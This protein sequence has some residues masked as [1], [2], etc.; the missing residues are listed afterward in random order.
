M[1]GQTLHSA[2]HT[3]TIHP[4]QRAHHHYAR[5]AQRLDCG[6]W[7]R[8]CGQFAARHPE[9]VQQRPQ[10]RD[11]EG[12]VGRK[13]EEASER[14]RRGE[15]DHHGQRGEHQRACILDARNRSFE[16]GGEEFDASTEGLLAAAGLA[17][18]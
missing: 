16:Q 1:D 14:V 9:V 4:R 10:R 8:V 6:A 17:S 13:I 11:H 18:D 5:Q 15:Q 12:R 3:S 2:A 7:P